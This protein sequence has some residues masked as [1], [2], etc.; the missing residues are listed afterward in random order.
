MNIHDLR[1]LLDAG[2]ISL[3]EFL[4]LAALISNHEA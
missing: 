1:R 3:K 4:R 2:F